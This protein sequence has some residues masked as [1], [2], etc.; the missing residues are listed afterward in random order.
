MVKTALQKQF[1]GKPIERAAFLVDERTRTLRAQL[2]D[3]N[4]S[5]TPVREMEISGS[6]GTMLFGGLGGNLRRNL[7]PDPGTFLRASVDIDYKSKRAEVSI[8]FRRNNTDA[9]NIET[10]T[11]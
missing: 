7:R 2:F 4:G 5:I 6:F 1:P 3:A 9:R 10:H 11:F 8:F